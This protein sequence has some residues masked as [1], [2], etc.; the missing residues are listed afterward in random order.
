MRTQAVVM[1][2]LGDESVLHLE[3][4]ELAAP[5]PGE[6]LLRVLAVAVNHLDLEL[7]DGRSRMPLTFPHVL[8]RE[9]VGE[10]VEVGDPAGSEWSAGDRVVLLPHVPCG[11]CR[12]CLTGS[13]NIC[14]AGWMPGIH[15]WGGY[16]RHVLAP[17]RGLRHVPDLPVEVLAALPISFGT[18]WR[19]LHSAA[20]VVTGDWVL[21]PGAGGGLGHA[22]VQVAALAGAR[23]IGLVRSAAKADF[24]KACGAEHVVLTD[25]D[26]WPD[27]VRGLTDGRG[28][29]VVVEHVGGDSFEGCLAA[30]APRGTLV[31][32]GGHGGEHPRLDVIEVFRNELRVHGVRSQRPDDVERVLDLAAAGR[33]RPQVDQVFSLEQAADAHRR[34]ASRQAVG[35]VVLVP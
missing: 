29:D 24:V 28:V 3:D 23:V 10:V 18:A 34:V 8:G 19:A 31:V 25:T 17:V 13:A 5:G 22:S 32:A 14:L 26:G 33:L 35:K 11:R 7:R 21:V 27:E 16:A 30:L 20:S 15:G 12:H 9:L 6:V 2:E 1:R 4:V